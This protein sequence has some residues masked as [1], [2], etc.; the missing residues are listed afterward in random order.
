MFCEKCG[1]PIGEK[2]KFCENCGAPVSPAEEAAPPE[3][4]QPKAQETAEAKAEPSQTQTTPEQETSTAA[5]QE[6]LKSEG[7]ETLKAET[8]EDSKAEIKKE[9]KSESQET[10]KSAA[11]ETPKEKSAKKFL[12]STKG[13]ILISA[14]AAVLLVLVVVGLNWA[15]LNNWIHKTFSSPAQ[16]YQYAEQQTVKDAADIIADWYG[17]SLEHADVYDMGLEGEFSLSVGQDVRDLM[18][19]VGTLTGVDFSAADWVE[20]A[21]VSAGMD[22]KDG[23][24]GLKGSLSA[25]GSSLLSLEAVGD[26]ANGM[27]YL[28]IPELSDTYLEMDIEDVLPGYVQSGD[29]DPEELRAFWKQLLKAMPSQAEVKK[30]AEKYLTLALTYVEDVDLKKRTLKAE[31]V[32]QSTTQL[33]VTVDE[34]TAVDMM[35]GVLEALE[36]DKDVEKIIRK[37]A[38]TAEENA[39]LLGM[40][41]RD[42]SP[43]KIYEMFLDG[44]DDALDELDGGFSMD[45]IKMELYVDGRGVIRGRSVEADG[46]AL[47]YRMPVKGSKFGYELTYEYYGESA[48]LSGSGKLSGDKVTGSFKVDAGRGY[49]PLVIDVKG[50]DKAALLRGRLNGTVEVSVSESVQNLLQTVAGYDPDDVD[51]MTGQVLDSVFRILDDCSVVLKAETNDSAGSYTVSLKSGKDELLG[52]SASLKIG[53]GEKAKIPA[54]NSTELVEDLRDLGNWLE[55]VDWDKV[56]ARYEKTALPNDILDLLEDFADDVEDEGGEEALQLWW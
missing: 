18:G 6:A 9:S 26:D 48:G 50:L 32:Q 8:Q 14:G 38:A 28:R 49:L 20:K 31:D 7:Q 46:S 16:Y 55:D 33:K 51:R 43:D 10:S 13:K 24:S 23:V 22:V 36:E 45:G 54:E 34:D 21:T 27:F 30:L 17:N 44:I 2:D 53:K 42:A 41:K 3:A 52:A 37:V 39:D 29:V 4:E 12:G 5:A 47:T 15:R 56:I 1:H 11:Q 40:R 19:T 35:K 25:N